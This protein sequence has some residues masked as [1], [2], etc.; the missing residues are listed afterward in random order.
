MVKILSKL[1]KPSGLKRQFWEDKF[2]RWYNRHPP[3]SAESGLAPVIDGDQYK[4]LRDT[5]ESG[6][7][8]TNNNR[9]SVGGPST[10]EYDLPTPGTVRNMKDI[11]ENNNAGTPDESVSGASP[12]LRKDSNPAMDNMEAARNIWKNDIPGDERDYPGKST[13]PPALTAPG[14]HKYEADDGT[15]Y[16]DA[17]LA[18]FIEEFMYGPRPKVSDLKDKYE[19]P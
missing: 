8:G 14:P 10:G 7:G 4:S 15:E 11:Y 16:T 6:N 18:N 5:F 3:T 17:D 2:Y 9:P 1:W 19:P 12:D 13:S